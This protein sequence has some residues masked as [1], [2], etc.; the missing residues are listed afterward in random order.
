MQEASAHLIVNFADR[1]HHR[2]QRSMNVG[3]KALRQLGESKATAAEVEKIPT[4]DK[5][6]DDQYRYSGR[7]SECGRPANPQHE[8]FALASA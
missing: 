4:L 1:D 5:A 2:P 3:L 8:T 7:T 6:G